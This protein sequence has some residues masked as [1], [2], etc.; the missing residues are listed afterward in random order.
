MLNSVFQSSI[1]G[2]YFTLTEKKVW[3]CFCARF[4]VAHLLPQPAI[5]K[6]DIFPVEAR[7]KIMDRKHAARSPERSHSR[8]HLNFGVN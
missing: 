7:E 5:C 3:A 6:D 4:A 2:Y 8:P 1:K